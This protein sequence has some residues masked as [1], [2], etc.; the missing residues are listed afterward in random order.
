VG[1]NFRIPRAGEFVLSVNNWTN[2]MQM[3]AEQAAT[4]QRICEHHFDALG[5][6]FPFSS[7]LA[8]ETGWTLEY[9]FRVLAEYKR[10]A[11][12]AKYAGHTVS[13]SHDIDEAWHL[14]LIYT[15]AYWQVFCCE[16]LGYELH[17]EPSTGG[18]AESDLYEG[19][20]EQTL[21]SYERFFGESPPT[22]IWPPTGQH[23]EGDKLS[24]KV[25]QNYI[26][27]KRP[28]ALRPR[29]KL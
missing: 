28:K 29:V 17:H 3:T 20:Y 18:Q 10:F 22:D 9:T 13:P 4:W 1:L 7:R 6:T 15:R 16:V 14:H 23:L 24:T 2:A 19:C 27:I 12:L 5:A 26:L 8:S 25:R 21:A 11:F